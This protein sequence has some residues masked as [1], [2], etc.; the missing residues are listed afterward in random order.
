M[1]IRVH[2]HR[3]QGYDLLSVVH[4]DDV[5]S[6]SSIGE[7]QMKYRISDLRLVHM[8]EQDPTEMVPDTF[9]ESRC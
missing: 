5:W 1:C 7:I 3:S 8:V 9:R 4:P 2:L 6:L